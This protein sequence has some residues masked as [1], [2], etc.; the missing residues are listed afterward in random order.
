[1]KIYFIY[2]YHMISI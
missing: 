2:Y 1:M